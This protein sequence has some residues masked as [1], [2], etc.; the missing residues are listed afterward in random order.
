MMQQIQLQLKK[1][2]NLLQQSCMLLSPFSKWALLNDLVYNHVSHYFSQ[3]FPTIFRFLS[4]QWIILHGLYHMGIFP[5]AYCTTNFKDFSNHPIFL[6][7]T[8]SELHVTIIK[9][10]R[11][12]LLFFISTQPFIQVQLERLKS[13]AMVFFT[14]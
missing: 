7:V 11:I 14:F 9:T 3:L 8:H 1:I 10:K 6:K 12:S 4:N 5:W 2:I 13:S